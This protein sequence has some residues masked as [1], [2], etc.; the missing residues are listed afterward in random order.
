MMEIL[1]ASPG[2]VPIPEPRVPDGTASVP[3]LT[4]GPTPTATPD[5]E[6]AAAM[7]TS[8]GG[9]AASAG[10]KQLTRA[11]R[12]GDVAAVKAV[13][14]EGADVNWVNP[15]TS[16]AP[17]HVAVKQG[18]LA[19][20]QVLLEHAADPNLQTKSGWTAM[21]FAVNGSAHELAE[22]LRDFGARSDVVNEWLKG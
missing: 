7:T 18:D 13:L 15:I 9:A 4:L 2:G 12:A 5:A 21:H 11:V 16:I 1:K 10:A 3:S 14:D 6:E 17:L 8:P 20:T 22:L 19:V